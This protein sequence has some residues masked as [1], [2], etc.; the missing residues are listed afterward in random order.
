MIFCVMGRASEAPTPPQTQP[1]RRNFML[2][3][4]CEQADQ[5]REATNRA[6]T[7]AG[8][9]FITIS[10]VLRATGDIKDPALNRIVDEARRNGIGYAI[11]R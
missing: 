8:Y 9:S 11:Y 6:L 7:S 1:Q 4:D 5:A 10:R 2:A 3:V